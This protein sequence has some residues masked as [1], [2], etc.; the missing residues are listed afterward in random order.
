[1]GEAEFERGALS[2]AVESALVE[3]APEVG[4]LRLST[5]GGRFHVRWDENGSASALRQFPSLPSFWR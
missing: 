1:M 2:I 4:D 5:P 3:V